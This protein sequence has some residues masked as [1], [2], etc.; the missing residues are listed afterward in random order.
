MATGDEVKKEKL[1][2]Q[3]KSVDMVRDWPTICRENLT[4]HKSEDMQQEAIEI[5]TESDDRIAYQPTNRLTAQEAM[6]KYTIEKVTTAAPA[7]WEQKALTH[8][9]GH[10]STYQKRG[11]RILLLQGQLLISFS[12]TP[13]RVQPGIA[14]SVAIL[15][16]S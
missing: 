4:R 7:F 15:A 8:I 3:V 9:A 13:K 14:L 1:E 6:E 16:V 12:S 10:C 5:G 2:P 11:T